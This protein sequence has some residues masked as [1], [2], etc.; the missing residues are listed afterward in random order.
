MET[1]GPP[2]LVKGSARAR[3]EAHGRR[4]WEISEQL[5]DVH[6]DFG[7]VPT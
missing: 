3:D 4:L 1:V 6:Y 5:T 2:K 7:G